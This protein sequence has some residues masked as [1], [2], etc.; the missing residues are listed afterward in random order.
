MFVECWCTKS[1]IA[2]PPITSAEDS[3]PE[4]SLVSSSSDD[5]DDDMV[6]PQDI[7]RSS[8]QDIKETLEL[9]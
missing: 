4:I 1:S 5:S 7:V 3:S 6:T 9:P 8:F 2:P